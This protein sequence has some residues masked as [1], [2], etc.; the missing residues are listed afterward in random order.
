ERNADVIL[1]VDSFVDL[2]AD[3]ESVL[4][5]AVRAATALADGYL[6][7][8]D[9]VGVVGFGGV[10]RWLLPGLGPRHLYRV[11]ESLLDTQVVTSYA[12]RAIDVI[13]PR[14][15]PPSATIVA[16]TPLL[17][18]RSLG[19]LVDLHQRGFELVVIEISAERFLPV[20]PGAPDALALQLWALQRLARRRTL[21]RAG[22]V[23]VEWPAQESF[24]AVLAEVR[25]YRRFARRS[26]A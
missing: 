8:R 25:E 9:R 20:G 19:A 5:L 18:A 22:L 11:V 1:F 6:G 14:V 12:W 24:E 2:G 13:P 10:L 15:L 23:V 21:Q 17:D 3:Q 16:L 7:E 4:T 26:V